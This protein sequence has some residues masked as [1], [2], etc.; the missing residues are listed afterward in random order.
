MKYLVPPLVLIVAITFVSATPKTKIDNCAAIHIGEFYYY[1]ST[2]NRKY[3]LI[4]DSG[5]QKEINLTT[6]DTSIFKITWLD[7][8]TYSLERISGIPKYQEGLKRPKLYIQF[9]TLKSN[10]YL[11]KG[12]KDFLHSNYCFKDTIWMNSK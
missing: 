2:S 9:S 11:F 5:T 6:N 3:K 4:R 8:C 12:C 1:P 7:D 10:Y